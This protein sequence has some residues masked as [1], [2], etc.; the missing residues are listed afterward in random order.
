MEHFSAKDLEDYILPQ[1]PAARFMEFSFQ[2]LSRDSLILSAPLA[3][4][5]NDKGTA[6]GG[7]LY[8]ALVLAGWGLVFGNLRDR[9]LSGD[10]VIARSTMDYRAPVRDDFMAEAIFAESS[11]PDLFFTEVASGKRTGID[12]MVRLHPLEEPP[13]IFQGTYFAWLK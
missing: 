2:H 6:F 3:P 9:G 12:V 1:T 5:I 10:V 8:S 13:A 11:D 7:S 4:S